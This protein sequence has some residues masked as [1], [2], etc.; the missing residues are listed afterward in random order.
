MSNEVTWQLENQIV[1]MRLSGVVTVEDI[2]Q[3]SATVTSMMP[4]E[5]ARVH[6]VVDLRD[7]HKFPTQ[8][9]DLAGLIPN[10]P[11]RGNGWLLFVSQNAFVRFLSST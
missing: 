9:R 6:L 11:R 2:K 10:I 1:Y 5:T 4:S 7:L 3:A 8:L